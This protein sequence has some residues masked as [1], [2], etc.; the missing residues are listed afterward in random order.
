MQRRDLLK[1]AAATAAVAGIAGA[2]AT[3]QGGCASVPRGPAAPADPAAAR[4]YLELLDRSL[5]LTPAMRPVHEL[6]MRAAAREPTAEEQ[7]VLDAHDGLFQ[8]MVRALF[9]TQSFRDLDPEVQVHPEVQTRMASHL[10]EIDATMWDVNNFLAARTADERDGLRQALRR[11]PRLAMDV[12]EA[13]D[14]RAAAMG[15]AKQRRRQLR[16]IMRQATF[17]M[18]TEAPG[19]LIDEYTEKVQRLAGSDGNTALALAMAKQLG[20]QQ[21]WRYQHLVAQDAGAGGATAATATAGAATA[22]TTTAPGVTPPAPP[23]AAQVM[24]PSQSRPG[25]GAIRAGAYML[26]IGVLDFAVG[27][28]IVSSASEGSTIAAIALVGGI[29]IGALLVA[30]GFIVLLV[31]GL[32]RLGA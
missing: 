32:M 14:L 3:T 28:V 16:H 23:R 30:I 18:R 22:T 8:R 6:A 31:G 11:N 19:A 29:T 12:A 9:V 5:A 15:V 13:L 26:G 24:T 25:D 1:Q 21:F 7:Q 20:E 27:A 10:D 17:R 4:A 2:T